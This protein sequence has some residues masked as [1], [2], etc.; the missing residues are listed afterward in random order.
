M[1]ES[2]AILAGGVFGLL[3]MG[4]LWAAVRIL[5]S[6]QSVWLFAAMGLLR[7]G[8]LVGALWLVLR[9]GATASNLVFGVLGFI[10]V[11][12]LATRF[13]KPAHPERASWK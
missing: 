7:A 8:L 11:R 5:T 6:G 10:A 9:S 13:V 4:V 2:L 12:L 3:Y 1:T